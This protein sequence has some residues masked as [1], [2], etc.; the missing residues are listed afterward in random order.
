VRTIPGYA[1]AGLMGRDVY[2][3]VVPEDVD[4]VRKLVRDSI[5][6]PGEDLAWRCRIRAARGEVQLIEINLCNRLNDPSVWA[7]VVNYR[8]VTERIRLEDALRQAAKMEA[9]G[10]LAGGIAH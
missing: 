3:L 2:G 1:P 10:R 7:I 6:R 8:D 4:S 5:R 9:V